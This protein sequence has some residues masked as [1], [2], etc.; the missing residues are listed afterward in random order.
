MILFEHFLNK[1]KLL[2]M[3]KQD[4][5]LRK[6]PNIS[7]E[8]VEIADEK[9]TEELKK[10]ITKIGWPTISKVG[11][12][13]A[14]A[15]WLLAQHTKDDE[16]REKCLELMKENSNDVSSKDIAFLED[17][18]CLIKYGY[19]IYG[20]QVKTEEKESRVVTKLLP[21]KDPHNL[22]RLRKKVGLDT[23]EEQIRRCEKMYLEFLKFKN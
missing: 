13:A 17:R 1:I 23:I 16:F 6:N 20:T 14:H 3:A 8:V 2:Q 11:K 22:R 19:Q 9:N 10:I 12:K 7:W 18:V 15:S 4:Q 5:K 21:I